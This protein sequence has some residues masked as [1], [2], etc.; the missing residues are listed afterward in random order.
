MRDYWLQEKQALE[1]KTQE[2]IEEN[3]HLEFERSRLKEGFG[4][5]SAV[6]K[7]LSYSSSDL[8]GGSQTY[9]VGNTGNIHD[10]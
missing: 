5:R 3:S 2:L 7:L 8:L 1:K 9:L 10:R 6:R 4:S